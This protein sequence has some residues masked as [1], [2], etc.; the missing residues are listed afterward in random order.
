M[1]KKAAAVIITAGT[2]LTTINTAHA[3]SAD[4]VI[5]AG[6]YKC[7]PGKR[8]YVEPDFQT[9]DDIPLRKDANGYYI[10]EWD[11]NMKLSK[12]IVAYLKSYNVNV[13]LQSA[14]SKSEDLN[15][16]GRIAK[17]KNPIIYFSVHHNY[18]NENS[19]GYFM[20]VNTDSE[21]DKRYAE[22]LSEALSG[23]PGNIPKM[24]VREQNGYIGEMNVKPGRV[25]LLM[26]AGFFSNKEELAKIIDDIQVD[27]MARQVAKVLIKILAQEDI[28]C[29][30]Q[31]I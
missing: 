5:R 4:I 8:I 29:F 31:D 7:K 28:N 2:V 23:N 11:I 12:R 18:Y 27:Y 22:A 13:D 30:C 26:E 24:E 6:E 1:N 9:P 19:S 25:N 10:S 3:D 14:Y 15:A 21:K 17:A 16:A 20:M